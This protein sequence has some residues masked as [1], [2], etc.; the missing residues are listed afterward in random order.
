MLAV[1]AILL[2]LIL[3]ALIPGLGQLLIYFIGIAIIGIAVLLAIYVVTSYPIPSLYLAGGVLIGGA[4]ILAAH[5][6]LHLSPPR[7]QKISKNVGRGLL[8]IYAALMGSV[9]IMGIFFGQK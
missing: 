5:W 3:L 4:F 6:L 1:I 9:L 2:F 8:V 7:V